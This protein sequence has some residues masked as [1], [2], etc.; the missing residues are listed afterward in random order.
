LSGDGSPALRDHVRVLEATHSEQRTRREAMDQPSS[1]A[2]ILNVPVNSANPPKPL[3]PGEYLGVINGVPEPAKRGPKETECVLFSVKL[4]RP[5]NV[6]QQALNEALDGKS[7][8][9][10]KLTHTVWITPDSVWRL[11]QFLVD[12]L[13]ITVTDTTTFS[14]ALAY[15]PGKE[16]KVIISHYASKVDGRIGMEIKSTGRAA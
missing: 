4:A 2:D 3:P 6:D 11:K 14:E 15:A 7:L 1:F 8:S 13:G 9:D 16:L 12:H 10:V 5:I